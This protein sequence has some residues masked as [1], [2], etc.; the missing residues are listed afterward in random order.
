MNEPDIRVPIEWLKGYYREAYRIVQAGAPHWISMF[1]DSFRL[2]PDVWAL[3]LQDCNNCV[4]DTH[5]YEVRV[6]IMVYSA[7]SASKV[8]CMQAWK[9]PQSPEWYAR[10]ICTTGSRLRELKQLG[11]EVVV[12]EWSLATGLHRHIFHE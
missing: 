3:F 10:D 12:G 5:I 1:H 7:I 9:L 11:V 6:P 4:M 8:D 2:S